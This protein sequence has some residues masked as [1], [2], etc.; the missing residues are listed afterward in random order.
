MLGVEGFIEQVLSP[1]MHTHTHLSKRSGAIRLRIVEFQRF[2][3]ALSVRPGSRCRSARVMA[4]GQARAR[5]GGGLDK[6]YT[7]GN[8]KRVQNAHALPSQVNACILPLSYLANLDPVVAQ[9]GVGLQ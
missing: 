1:C 6:K 2:L 4:N 8:L 9:F 7:L 5:G 3:I